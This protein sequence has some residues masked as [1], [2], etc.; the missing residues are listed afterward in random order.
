MQIYI[1]FLLSYG[2]FLTEVDTVL[3][4]GEY[5]ILWGPPIYWKKHYKGW[6][7]TQED[8][9]REQKNNRECCKEPMLEEGD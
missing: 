6:E 5:W 2:L 4:P 8:L 9:N 3:R 7:R 1:Y